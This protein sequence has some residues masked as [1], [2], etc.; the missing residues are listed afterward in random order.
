MKWL[1]GIL[2]NSPILITSRTSPAA[3]RCLRRIE[4][5]LAAFT[6]DDFRRPNMTSS[7]LGS[8]FGS[9][10]AVAGNRNR[11]HSIA[12]DHEKRAS[13][14]HFLGCFCLFSAARSIGRRGKSFCSKRL[15]K[16]A[17]RMV[18]TKTFSNSKFFFALRSSVLAP[19]RRHS[20]FLSCFCGLGFPS[21]GVLIKIP[22]ARL[23]LHK[24]LNE[25]R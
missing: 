8:T 23:H 19:R 21:L 1:A 10:S 22:F 15:S 11:S 5:H 25:E 12:S 18:G 3:K 20:I 7:S 24:K 2:I 13:Y 16:R 9:D 17:R 14:C 6:K 4:R